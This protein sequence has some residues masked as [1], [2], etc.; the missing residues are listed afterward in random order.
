MTKTQP[1]QPARRWFLIGAALLLASAAALQARAGDALADVSVYDRAQKRFL[2]LY[3]HEGRAYV[4]GTPGNEYE[5]V[6]RNRARGDVLAVVSVD[7]VNAVTGETAN[8]SQGGY[9]VRDGSTTRV[10][11]WRKSLGETAAF[12]FTSLGDSYAGRTG[13]PDNVGVIGVALF[14]RKPA[15]IPWAAPQTPW[16]QKSESG[17]SRDSAASMEKRHGA[18]PASAPLGTGHGRR[19]DSPATTTEF[20]RASLYPSQVVTIHY[21]SHRNLVAQGIIPPAYGRRAPDPFPQGFV[22]D[23]PRYRR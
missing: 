19:Q 4:V 17:A 18:P 15:A 6:V 10:T 7:G 20:E 14:E 23:P 1:L 8:A 13:R 2:P 16:R 5:I 21:D 11:G 22:P 12:Y 3:W 9:V